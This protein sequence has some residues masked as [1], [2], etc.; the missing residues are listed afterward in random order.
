MLYP[1]YDFNVYFFKNLF[2]YIFWANLV[3]KSEVLQIIPTLVQGY[4]D[5][6]LLRFYCLFFQKFWS[7]YYGHISSHLVFT[8]LPEFH[9]ISM[10]NFCKYGEQQILGW[11]LSQKLINSKYLKI[12]HQNR[13]Q[14]ITMYPYIKFQSIWR[15][16]DFGTKLPPKKVTDKKIWKNKTLRS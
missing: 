13:N 11:N 16:L 5:I 6:C 14:H 9:R 2:I 1:Y 7:Q 4:I 10:L 15:T 3:R 12:T 8:K